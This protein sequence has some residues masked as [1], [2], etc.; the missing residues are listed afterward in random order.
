ML[1]SRVRASHTRQAT[2]AGGSQTE[3]SL[4]AFKSFLGQVSNLAGRGVTTVDGACLEAA[5][6]G[7]SSINMMIMIIIMTMMMIMMMMMMM[8]MLLLFSDVI[9]ICYD[10]T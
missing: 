5:Q 8:M 10:L 9:V 1:H 3:A 6:G 4:A 2:L 7:S